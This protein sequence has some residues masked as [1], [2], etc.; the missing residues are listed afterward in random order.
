MTETLKQVLA[1]DE[2][3]STV[4]TQ[5]PVAESNSRWAFINGWEVEPQ[6]NDRAPMLG[7]VAINT[8]S[9]AA[10]RSSTRRKRQA[11]F[12]DWSRSRHD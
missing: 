9:P 5:L 11:M 6:S 2:A 1:K 10:L 8:A 4:S 3:P 7:H 12:K